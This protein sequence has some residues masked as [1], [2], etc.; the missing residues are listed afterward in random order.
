MTTE[1]TL[2]IDGD[3]LKPVTDLLTEI[4]DRLPR[5]KEN[6]TAPEKLN[7]VH[8]PDRI[9]LYRGDHLIAAAREMC[10]EPND[11]RWV[12]VVK[13]RRGHVMRALNKEHAVIHI[14]TLAWLIQTGGR[15]DG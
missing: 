12:I 3:P 1:A 10:F 11:W 15:V 13:E 4:R 8:W 7:I 14:E 5:P 6:A 2:T 9:E